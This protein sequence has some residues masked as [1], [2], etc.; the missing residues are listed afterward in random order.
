MLLYAGPGLDGGIIAAVLGMLA[1]F[2]LAIFALIWLP[3][4]KGFGKLKSMFK[5]QDEE[6][7]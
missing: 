2:V 5:K 1:S 3:L 4:R 7:K 6:I